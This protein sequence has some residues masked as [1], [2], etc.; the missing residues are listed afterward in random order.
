MA[1]NHSLGTIRGTIEIDYDGAGI[2]KAVRDTDKAKGAMDRLNKASNKTLSGFETFAKG[3]LI[4]AGSVGTAYNALTLITGVLAAVGPLASA[5]FA[6]APGVVLGFAAA[7]VITKIA[8]AGV[9]EAL[10]AAGEDAQKF[11]KAIE[12][13]SPQAQKFARAFR[14]ARPELIAT[15][16]AIQDAFFKGTAGQIQGVV[17]RVTSLQRQAVAVAGSISKIAQE[18]IRTATS[19][20]SLSGIRTILTGVNAF[21]VRI[22]G[23]IGPVVEAFI[24]L[25]ARA[26][27]FGGIAGGSVASALAKLASWLNSIDV[28][29]LFA[30][31][32]PIARALG[33]LFSNI[34]IIAGQ[35]FGLF[36][37]DGATS[38]GILSQ[39]AASLATFLQSAQG[40]EA[41]TALGLAIQA[42]GGAAGQIFIAFLQA[43]TPIIVALAPGIA[44]LAGQ[45]AGVLVPALAAVSPILASIA[46]FLSENM[47]WIGPLAGAVV[48]AA[49]AYKAYAAAVTIVAAVK[50]ALN[51]QMAI[52]TAAW[53]ANTASTVANRVATLATAA[54]TGGAAVGA[55]IASTAAIVANRVAL[56][57]G[58][59]AM[60]VVKA[61]TAAWTA[62]QWLLNAAL[63]ANPIGLVI[64]AIALL[65]AGIIYAWKNSETFRNVVMTVWGAI[66]TAIAAVVNWIT[67]TVW[68]ALKSAWDAVANAAKD[69]WNKIKSAWNGILNAIRTAINA[70]RAVITAVWSFIVNAVKTYLTTYRNIIVTGFNFVRNIITTVMNTARNIVRTVWAAIVNVISSQIAR[71]RAVITTIRNVVTIIRSA[72]NQAV[73]AVRT[74]LNNAISTVRQLPGRIA[75]AL[76]NLGSLLYNKGV[77]LV[78]GFINGIKSMIGNVKSVASSVVSAVTDFL[79]GSPAKEGPL[80]GR[81]YALL[82]ARR[83]MS[84]FAQG[85]EDGSN[86]PARVMLGAVTPMAR[87]MAPSGST[88]ISRAPVAPPVGSTPTGTREYSLNIGGK[89]FARLVVDAVTGEPKTIAKAVSEGNREITWAGSGR[90]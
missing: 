5:A 41:L 13:L 50:K 49:A 20:K 25:A 14:A 73:A 22:R 67:G 82:R 3:A 7:L 46:G 12:K 68:P 30:K 74:A 64:A 6:A 42:I 38:I 75:G 29:A 61:A 19:G 65:V 63:T 39:L 26:A 37:V 9:G 70:A 59:V 90:K 58:V 56:L 55:W 11:E 35:L 45:I 8:M 88:T 76:G 21:L 52:S 57:A 36:N 62:V 80:S 54:V 23:S 47:S 34:A 24:A 15:K 31:A 28:E 53:V 66:K 71:I 2:V 4:V 85:I 27:E 79:P 81:G 1:G 10:G 32:L 89:E 51:T 43:V 69:L 16:N 48:A 40:Q 72:F 44:Q 83:M 84:D 86:G 17:Q 60:G 77:S 33:D 78:Q 87:A 18:V